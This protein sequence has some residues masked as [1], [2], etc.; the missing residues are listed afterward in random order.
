MR[1]PEPQMGNDIVVAGQN[2]A[3]MIARQ[4]FGMRELEVRAETA[5]V[6]IAA[7]AAATVK[8]RYAM[9][10][11]R[12]RDMMVVRNQLLSDLQRTRFA[13]TSRYAKPVGGQKIRGWSIRFAEAAARAMGNIFIETMV[14]Y[15]NPRQRI[16]RVS[17]TD[18]ESNV[19][20]T[21]DVTIDKTVERR[22]PNGYEIISQ[23]TNKQGDNVFIVAATD[24]DLQNK[25]NS[26]VSKAMRNSILRLVP[27]DILEDCLDA[28]DASM[29]GQTKDPAAALKSIVD[30][31][32]RLGVPL[33]QLAE[34]LGHSLDTMTLEER[35]DLKQIGVAIKDGEAKWSDYM[36][37][38]RESRTSDK[39]EPTLTDEPP[40]NMAALKQKAKAKSKPADDIALHGPSCP[41]NVGEK[42]E[43]GVTT[44]EPG[45]DDA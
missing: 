43:C 31:F 40:K 13:E 32:T 44:R 28:Y 24:D 6:A 8:A 10:L 19:P 29:R 2:G 15:E 1:R 34:Y 27:G 30:G 21:T 42:C 33:E 39:K 18:L 36:A 5:S 35:E 11:E 38:R 9:A 3:G 14:V 12:P 26:M 25:Q 7:Q 45:S 41:A 4:D 17:V 20:Y 23:R 16:I 37:E 22:N